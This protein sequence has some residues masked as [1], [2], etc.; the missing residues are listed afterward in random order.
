MTNLFCAQ[1][2]DDSLALVETA[3]QAP[4]SPIPS[5]RSSHRSSKVSSCGYMLM[6]LGSRKMLIRA[7]PN[8]GVAAQSV[9]LAPANDYKIQLCELTAIPYVTSASTNFSEWVS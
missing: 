9:E 2:P 5:L 8:T 4:P 7:D 1:E 3:G 6:S